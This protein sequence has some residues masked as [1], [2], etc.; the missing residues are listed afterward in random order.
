MSLTW[1]MAQEVRVGRASA[2]T[3]LGQD[4]VT[5]SALTISNP[6]DCLVIEGHPTELRQIAQRLLRQASAT[7]HNEL[8][9]KVALAK[10]YAEAKTVTTQKKAETLQ[11]AL[12]FALDLLGRQDLR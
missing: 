5:K 6:G 4:T 2:G 10:Q 11:S 7:D 8:T 3:E 1:F 9:A 12:D